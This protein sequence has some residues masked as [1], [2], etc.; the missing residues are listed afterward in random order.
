M[1]GVEGAREAALRKTLTMERHVATLRLI[2]VSFNITVYFL[3]LW[4]DTPRRPLALSIVILAGAYALWSFFFRPYERYPLLRFGA[5]TLV[6]DV[7]LITLWVLGTGGTASPF[8]VIYFVSVTSVAMRYDVVQT[9]VAAAGEAV[10]Y[11]VAMVLD[12]GL[13]AAHAASRPAYIMIAGLAAGFLARQERIS[14]DERVWFEQLATEHSAMLAR[15]REVVE[16][17]REL[18][19]MK[20]EFVANAAH[21]LRT[22][23]TTLSGLA[24]TLSYRWE[25]LTAK[26][27][28]DALASMRRQGERARVLIDNLLDLSALERGRLMIALTPVPLDA[29]FR[30]ALETAPP[31]TDKH[32]RVELADGVRAIADPNRLEQ[33]ITNL[34]T[35]AYRYGGSTITVRAAEDETTV[36]LTV[37]DDGSGVPPEVTA[38]LFEP[39]GRGDNVNGQP[40]SGLGLAI[41]HRLVE[42]FGGEMSYAPAEPSGAVFAVRLPAAS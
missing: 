38:H 7:V 6:S 28:A 13:P 25:A 40:G 18:D 39:F 29:V 35:N 42:A 17:L 27:I 37:A 10:V 30:N 11:S 31:P 41:S 2:V 3:F 20:T 8:W 5:A 15:E 16:Q 26:E 19:E 23:L 1:A 32:V 24:S 33:V 14:R 4:S 34:L 36:V 21:E 9:V 12:G 22:P